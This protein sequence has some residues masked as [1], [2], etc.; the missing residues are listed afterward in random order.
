MKLKHHRYSEQ[1]RLTEFDTWITPSLGDI[2][3]TIEFKN[4]VSGL[5]EG[6]LSLSTYT[7]G[8]ANADSCSAYQIAK[9]IIENF[10]EIKDK[11]S[12]LTNVFNAILLATGKSDNNLK[13]QY[14]IILQRLF[15]GNEIAAVKKGKLAKMEIPRDFNME[16]AINH[17]TS[18][19]NHPDLLA[20][21]L[22]SYIDLLLSDD[23]YI[24]QLYSLGKSFQTL[25]KE[26]NAKSLLSSIAIFQSR[27]SLTAKIGHLPEKILRSYMTDWGMKAGSDFNLD[28]INVYDLLGIA[29]PK[30]QKIRKFDFI[31]P[32]LSKNTGKKLFVQSQFYAG[33][34][35][36][37]SHKVVDQTDASRLLT[38]KK[39]P[40][41]V[42]VEYLDGAGYFSS[43]NG[44][45]KKMLA[46]KT[47]KDF[48]QIRTAPLKF[49]RELQDIDFITPLEIEHVVLKGYTSEAE[50]SEY[51]AKQ[52]YNTD[53]ISRSIDISKNGGI[54]N[55][56][57]G[58][59]SIQEGRKDIVFIYSLLDCIA[60]YGH[61]IN[62][63]KEKGVLCVPGYGKEWG[64]NQ[65]TLLETFTKEFPNVEMTAKDLLAKIQWLIDKEFV[66]LK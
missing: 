50:I 42:F 48:I 52:G 38:L 31:V 64:M 8:F 34:S 10:N 24:M 26:G 54:L 53:E 14:P 17:F 61:D 1:E 43:L 39:Y 5:E 58:D 62:R 15:G 47:T 16:K 25:S 51:L 60:N 33:D 11:E 9:G 19:V 12:H 66:I 4:V 55:Y 41:A 30:N 18:L 29:K 44:D 46:K 21:L 23:E 27:G 13:C 3:D 59:F 6:F 37:V 28:D 56:K 7:N 45:L 57:A 20:P 2:K 40:Q 22:K 63:N 65:N 32:Y 35:G 49:R 36:S